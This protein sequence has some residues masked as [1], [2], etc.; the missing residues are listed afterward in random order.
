MIRAI[1]FLKKIR[2]ASSVPI[3][4]I[5]VNFAPGSSDIPENSPKIRMCALDEIGRNSV[6]PWIIPKKIAS[7]ID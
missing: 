5:A 6:R 4:I 3:C 1:S 7:S 2:T